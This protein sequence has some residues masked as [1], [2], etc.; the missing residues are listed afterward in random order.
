[1]TEVTTPSWTPALGR[2][3]RA[4]KH[5]GSIPHMCPHG[6]PALPGI[7]FILHKHKATMRGWRE[8]ERDIMDSGEVD[9]TSERNPPINTHKESMHSQV[10]ICTHTQKT[11]N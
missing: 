8:R 10:K 3:C 4:V 11:I 6:E 9:R 1:M 7:G 2:A 5:A